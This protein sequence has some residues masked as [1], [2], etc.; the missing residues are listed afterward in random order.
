MI[1]VDSNVL[2]Y[3]HRSGVP[4]HRRARRAIERAAASDAGW[5]IAWP[6]LAEFWSV[7]THPAAS[8]PST[9]SE[10]SAYLAALF[11]DGGA[12]L[13]LPGVGF[14]ERLL[15]QAVELD[16]R[17]PR[18]FDL[19]IALTALEHGARELWTHDCSF[20]TVPGLTVHDPL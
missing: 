20:V 16:V 14:G 3:G 10:A 12:E 19:Q 17:G 8:R 7:V 13:W 9:A 11:T 18:I 1:A 2:I 4:E 5:G 15:R 6:A